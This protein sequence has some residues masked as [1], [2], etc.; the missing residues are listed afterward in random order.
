M[1]VDELILSQQDQGR[2]LHWQVEANASWKK[3]GE[4]KI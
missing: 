3:L 2:P 1:T 4:K